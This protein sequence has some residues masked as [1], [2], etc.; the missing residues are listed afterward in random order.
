MNHLLLCMK[1]PFVWLSRFR[2]RC[3]YGVHSPFAF[4]LITD[5][6][7]EKQPYYAYR[8]LA[9]EQK[10]MS[11]ERRWH[12]GTQKINRLLFRLVNRVQ[13][14]TIVEVG[15]LSVS[16]LYL[17]SAKP[18]AGYLFAS[19]LSEL[20]LDADVP[21]DFLYL[22]DY[23]N[24]D[25][26]KEAFR[27]CAQRTT[28]QSLFVVYGITYSKR[29]KTLWRELQNDERVGITFDLYD[30]GLLFFDKTKIKQHYMINF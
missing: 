4:S 10:K 13:P 18:S 29:M 14:S 3:G 7:Y 24:P 22:N 12:K 27:V 21:V 5:V 2:Y 20:F 28:P 16:S 26:V 30:A 15:R 9:L 25:L 1:R 17:Q 23:R 19:D 8:S 11:K 6:I